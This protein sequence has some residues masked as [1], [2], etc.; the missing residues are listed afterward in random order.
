MRA[1]SARSPKGNIPRDMLLQLT[2]Y[3]MATSSRHSEGIVVFHRSLVHSTYVAEDSV[4]TTRPLIDVAGALLIDLPINI[5]H[6]QRTTLS[7]LYPHQPSCLHNQV[8]MPQRS[9]RTSRLFWAHSTA[10]SIEEPLR[11]DGH[12]PWGFTAGAVTRI[13]NEDELTIL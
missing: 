1:T 10:D 11:D 3:M 5:P 6:S 2:M 13:G 7:C 4:N 8:T 12:R 9:L